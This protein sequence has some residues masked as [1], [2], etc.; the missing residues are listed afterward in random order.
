MVNSSAVGTQVAVVFCIGGWGILTVKN[1]RNRLIAFGIACAIS[2]LAYC[3]AFV[4]YV[5]VFWIDCL[6]QSDTAL[7]LLFIRMLLHCTVVLVFIY[8]YNA[9]PALK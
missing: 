8:R 4:Q 5:F 9:M 7:N 3:V 6:Q 2:V 1:F